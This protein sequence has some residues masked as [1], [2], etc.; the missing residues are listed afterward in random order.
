MASELTNRAAVPLS[1]ISETLKERGKDY[2]VFYGHAEI[3]Q[4]LKDVMRDAPGWK[5]LYP[6]MKE[7]LDM[8][9]HKIGRILNGNPLYIDSYRDICGY[10]KLVQDELEQTDGATDAKSVRLKRVNGEWV[11]A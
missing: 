8:V 10:I 11:E 2:G 5:K 4:G 9:V 1:E 3:T 7:A 6:S